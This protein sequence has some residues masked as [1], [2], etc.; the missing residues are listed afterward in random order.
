MA[1]GFLLGRV[2]VLPAERRRKLLLWLGLACTAGFVLLRLSNLYGD[3]QP[4]KGR[5]S[6]LFTVLS[7]MNTSKYPPSLLFLLMTIGPAL[8]VLRAVDGRTPKLLRWALVLGRVPFFYYVLH[9]L[10]LHLIAAGR[11][12]VQFGGVHWALESPSIDR[13]PMTQPPGWP[14]SLP[15]VYVMWLTVVVLAWPLCRWYSDVKRRRSDWW[16]SYL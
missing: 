15:M 9:A 11:A 1:A 8:L 12:I 4:W 13:F 6:G 10:I 16:L 14:M 2:L 7:F 3:P 5:S